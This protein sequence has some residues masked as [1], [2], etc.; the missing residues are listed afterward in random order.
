MGRDTHLGFISTPSFHAGTVSSRALF[1]MEEERKIYEKVKLERY[2][3]YQQ[4]HEDEPLK[5]GVAFQFVQDT[6]TIVISS[7]ALFNTD[8]D[9]QSVKPGVAF[10]FVKAVMTV[11]ALL[12]D[13]YPDANGQN[14]CK[15]IV[16]SDCF[17]AAHVCKT[18]VRP[19]SNAQRCVAFDGNADAVT[20]V[21]TSS[22]LFKKD[23]VQQSVKPGAAFPFVKALKEV[24][25]SLRELYPDSTEVFNIV[26]LH[27]DLTPYSEGQLRESIGTH[28]FAAAVMKNYKFNPLSDT[29]L[30]VAFDGDAV[31]F[32]D[33]SERVMHQQGLEAFLRH[34]Q[35]KKDIPLEKGPLKCFLEAL[36]KLQWKFYV[37]NERINC[38]VQT[39][40]VTSRSAASAGARVLKT[41]RSWGLEFDDAHFLAGA[42]KGPLLEMICPHIFFDDQMGHIESAQEHGIIAAHVKLA[43]A[44]ELPR[45]REGTETLSAAKQ[46]E[47]PLPQ[48]HDLQPSHCPMIAQ[49]TH[50]SQLA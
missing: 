28:G 23:N 16:L 4:L 42:P 17:E 21:I 40:L 36:G 2:V 13:L 45:L 33:E 46:K 30:R 5:P 37:K 3:A 41:L 15:T 18:E 43:V 14:L 49:L 20:I 44:M 9:Q 34:E 38:P 25:T 12:Q 27:D 26:L 22:A 39:Y 6:V 35:E 8:D 7:S 10:P 48:R 50:C 29:P 19:P 1:D 31:V 32:C 11:N 47:L 24:N